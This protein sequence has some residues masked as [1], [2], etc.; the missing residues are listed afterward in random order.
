M[1]FIGSKALFDSNR[2]TGAGALASEVAEERH[3]VHFNCLMRF[4]LAIKS[5]AFVLVP[6]GCSG[7]QPAATLTRGV[8]AVESSSSGIEIYCITI[9]SPEQSFDFIV[10]LCY[11]Y[12]ILQQSLAMLY[13]DHFKHLPAN[14]C[15]SLNILPCDGC[16]KRKCSS[17]EQTFYCNLDFSF[18]ATSSW[19]HCC[20]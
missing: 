1:V 10:C 18:S 16:W 19:I 13:I 20:H 9:S 5:L 11:R 12:M 6:S 17:T 14:F 3:G 4:R 15:S 2:S 8:K 7:E